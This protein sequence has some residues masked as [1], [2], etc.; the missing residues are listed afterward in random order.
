MS[1]LGLL[2]LI[3][4][5]CG[6]CG[7]ASE[8]DPGMKPIN[9][10]MRTG[11]SVTIGSDRLSRVSI[12]NPDIADL[13]VLSSRQILLNAK[14]QGNTDVYV[15]DKSG[16]TMYRV[17]VQPT[18][19]D[20]TTLCANIAKELNDPRVSVRS[21][22]STLMLEGTVGSDAE[23]VR[24]E[25]IANAV[26]ETAVFHG[27]YNEPKST[28]VKSVSRPEKDSFII[29]KSSEQTLNQVGTTS[30]W[31]TPRVVN[32]LKIENHMGQTSVRTI[33]TACA[34]RQALNNPCMSVRAMPGSVVMVEGK[35]G[36]TAELDHINQ[37]LKGWE[38]KGVDD[39]G[40][41][42]GSSDMTE[43]V[44]IVNAVT[45][46]SSSAQQ[47][48]VHAQ[49]LDINKKDLT[50][51]GVEWGN[52]FF[53]ANG[54]PIVTDQPFLVGE[55]EP[56]KIFQIGKFENLAPVGARVRALVTN[57]KAK[58]LSEPDLL[59]L[60]GQEASMLV[61]GEVPI[62]VVQNASAGSAVAITVEWKEFGVKLRM[63][64][65]LTGSDSMQ[66]KIAPEVS[67]IDNANSVVFN[68][69]V[70][71]AFTTRKA[72]STVN[73][74]DGQTLIIGGL[75]SRD[76]GKNVKKIPFLGDIPIIGE[77]FKTTSWQNDETELVIVITPRIVRP[78]L[79]PGIPFAPSGQVPIAPTQQRP[80][81]MPP[82]S[83]PLTP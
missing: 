46:D 53:D 16:Q 28:T 37:M 50:D 23:S 60:D 2:I 13:V 36:T 20:M 67:A 58:V 5:A 54:N 25:A 65:M 30:G 18:V 82:T 61:G 35:V 76:A 45:V 10:I 77:F 51:L 14:S 6:A 47:V 11:D 70:I 52:V 8:K 69:F 72:E 79:S 75:I 4:L 62:P 26:V 1:R 15:W 38:K 39:K 74:K 73:I 63:L 3:A 33:E 83:L 17:T 64:P 44:T 7:I 24:S 49:V 27:Y 40:M 34:I 32:L 19:P 59:V 78:G 21:V 68:G 31:R 48:L 71:P 80:S 57:N 42:A 22:G 9:V 55:T 81:L 43:K 56:S 12:G 66:L 29:E 41:I